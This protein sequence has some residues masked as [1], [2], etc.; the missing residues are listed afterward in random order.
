MESKVIRARRRND[1][2]QRQAQASERQ[3]ARQAAAFDLLL[4]LVAPTQTA[5]SPRLVAQ[6]SSLADAAVAVFD[7]TRWL[8]GMLGSGSVFLE[9]AEAAQRRTAAQKIQ[10]GWRQ[11]QDRLLRASRRELA[12]AVLGAEASPASILSHSP[13]GRPLRLQSPFLGQRRQ[14]QAQPQGDST[15]AAE[16]AAEA[17]ALLGDGERL[18]AIFRA[19]ALEDYGRASAR[20]IGV[21]ATGGELTFAAGETVWVFR[22]P[23]YAHWFGCTAATAAAAAKHGQSSVKSQGDRQSGITDDFRLGGT[24]PSDAV[25]VYDAV[26]LENDKCYLLS[27]D[28]GLELGRCSTR[29]CALAL[30]ANVALDMRGGGSGFARA[31]YAVGDLYASLSP[32]GMRAYADPEAWIKTKRKQE[33]LQAQPAPLGRKWCDTDVGMAQA[34]AVLQRKKKSEPEE[35]TGDR[36]RAAF[37][38]G[39]FRESVSDGM[40]N[41]MSHVEWIGPALDLLSITSGNVVMEWGYCVGHAVVRALAS[42]E[43]AR[44]KAGQKAEADRIEALVEETNA[45]KAELAELKDQQENEQAIL[46]AEKLGAFNKQGASCIELSGC[47]AVIVCWCELMLATSVAICC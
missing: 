14:P 41:G 16:D 31:V 11:R 3:W 17:A 19:V 9:T 18:G 10:G 1:A 36:I 38:S 37:E 42:L 47:E 2:K 8:L 32:N 40:D 12:S 27:V 20:V 26:G 23:L 29:E 46:V 15:A 25:K 13:G 6:A 35:T 7:K 5:Q 22:A 43:E 45:L 33:Q 34:A 30:R 44:Q 28:Q 4:P 39:W 24:F 21:T